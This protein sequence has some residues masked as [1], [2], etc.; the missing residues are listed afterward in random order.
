M[1]TIQQAIDN[2][3]RLLCACALALLPAS[4][5]LADS[6]RIDEGID[7]DYCNPERRPQ[8]LTAP[9]PPA[10]LDKPQ[11]EADQMFYDQATGETQLTGG[12][13]FWRLDGYAEADRMVYHQNERSADLFGNLFLQQDG[14]RLTAERGHLE[15]DDNRGWLTQ[16][17]FR[18]T[19]RHAR[20][21]A[22]RVEMLSRDLSRYQQVTYTTCPPGRHD[23]SLKASEMEIDRASGWGSATHA[24][25]RLG[26]V[27][28]FYFPYFTFPVDDRRMTGF[29]NPSLGSSN[30]L[31]TELETPYYLN[32]APNYDATLSPRYMSDRGLMMGGEFRYLDDYQRAEIRGEI[33]P[34]DRVDS[35]D[36]GDERRAFHF[37]H[38]SRLAAGLTTR[39]NTN[40]VSDNAY[41]DDFGSGLAVTST[42][43]LERV[44]EMVYRRDGLR[45]VGRLQEFQTVDANLNP[46]LYP[47]RR[48][49]QLLA[50][51][52][53]LLGDM[54]ID[55]DLTAE[56]TD[57]RHDTLIDGKRTILRPSMTLPL[58]RSWGFL[59]P[60]L[61][62]NYASYQLDE[63][64]ATGDANPDYFVPAFSL[65]SGLVF[66]RES[67]WFGSAAFQTLEPRLYYLYAPFDDQSEIPDFDT[68]DLQLSFSNL[69]KENRFTGSDRFGDANQIAFGLTTRWLEAESGVERF[70]ASIGQIYYREDREVQL[71]G[72]V[73]ETPSSSVVA[74]LSTR[75]GDYWRGILTVRRDPHVE[76]KNIDRGRLG[77]HY[78]APENR[79]L[80]LDYNFNRNTIED[81]DLSFNWPL[82]HKFSLT[83]KWKYSYLYERNTN[84]ILGFEYGG[85]CCW[86]L[87]ALYQSYLSDTDIKDENAEE[88]RRLMLQLVFTGLGGAG[89]SVND[90]LEEEI[91]GYRAKE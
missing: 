87:R 16:G 50:T 80:N 30:R 11:I 40:A 25:V 39:I 89:T 23:W 5:T 42:R 27:P 48:M 49:P 2:R 57:F 13:Q 59:V 60:R 78:R 69:F 18:L 17:E 62:L 33:L 32:L 44:G 34:D 41:L 28:I 37:Q 88:N 79:L 24:R 54:D 91:Y 82:S 7:W 43:H 12:V 75:V 4:A 22:E 84:R 53:R 1:N 6:I 72:A 70:R 14:L 31:G 65:D 20:G 52:G 86:K 51:Y 66:E 26:P 8:A 19:E 90:V 29:L 58:R 3:R 83:G 36:Y 38:S 9:P 55:L 77:I 61:S 81:L 85:R 63:N 73:E 47:Y 71:T 76:E 56:Y 45:L 46:R 64:A 67:S 15:L 68:A 21:G 10:P 74:E 35:P